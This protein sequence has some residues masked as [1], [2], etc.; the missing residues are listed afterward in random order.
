MVD[1]PNEKPAPSY[2]LLHIFENLG[3]GREVTKETTKIN[4]R[5][6]QDTSTSSHAQTSRQMLLEGTEFL[7]S[8]QDMRMYVRYQDNMPVLVEKDGKSKIFIQKPENFELKRQSSVFQL[9]M[10]NGS[11]FIDEWGCLRIKCAK[12]AGCNKLQQKSQYSL[13]RLPKNVQD[14]KEYGFLR[15]I[16]AEIYKER[17]QKVNGPKRK[18]PQIPRVDLPKPGKLSGCMQSNRVRFRHVEDYVLANMK[19]D[20]NHGNVTYRKL[21]LHYAR[22]WTTQPEYGPQHLKEKF[23]ASKGWA[24][25]FMLRNQNLFSSWSLQ[26]KSVST[27]TKIF[28]ITTK[29]GQR[30]SEVGLLPKNFEES[31]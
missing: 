8:D 2:G 18:K 25:K 4:D 9:G 10:A 5:F 27:G 19:N 13:Y 6:Q 24:D 31:L 29:S 1:T 23:R 3:L 20:A 7:R 11:V 16:V 12:F 21:A 28:E 22:K 14:I 15:K 17:D 26:K 30:Q